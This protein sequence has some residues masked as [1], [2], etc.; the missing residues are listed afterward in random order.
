MINTVPVNVQL[1][2]GHLDSLRVGR[3]PDSSE[4]VNGAEV[5]WEF[6][7]E[8]SDGSDDDAENGGTT[9]ERLEDELRFGWKIAPLRP[10]KT[11]ILLDKSV[12]PTDMVVAGSRVTSGNPMLNPTEALPRFLAA[13]SPTMT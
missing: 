9:D 5:E 8:N 4:L 6:D 12:K 13:A 11:V 10:W 3:H 1:P 7:Q 2:P